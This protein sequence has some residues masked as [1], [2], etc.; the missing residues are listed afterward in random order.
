M[1]P[2][3]T[4]MLISGRSRCARS[5]SSS[6][7][8][9]GRIISVTRTSK[10][11]PLIRSRAASASGREV[12]LQE[13]GQDRVVVNYNNGVFIIHGRG[14]AGKAA[15]GLLEQI[16]DLHTMKNNQLYML[17]IPGNEGV[18]KLLKGTTV[19]RD[20]KA[21]PENQDLLDRVMR[22]FRALRH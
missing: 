10:A 5:A 11:A 12:L 1:N 19:E 20:K 22:R 16:H 15:W 9:P 13:A 21:G 2:V 18:T 4:T 6:P 17:S 7:F 14:T 3:V 8:M